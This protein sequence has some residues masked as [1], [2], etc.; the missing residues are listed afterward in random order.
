MIRRL[1]IV[2]ASAML[3]G[4]AVPP[5]AMG[6]SQSPLPE[7]LRAELK[8]LPLT[9]PDGTRPEFVPAALDP[10]RLVTVMVEVDGAPVAAV[11]AAAKDAGAELSDVERSALRAALRARQQPLVDAVE[12]LRGRVLA[13]TQDAFNG[14]KVTV[15][16]SALPQLATL[17]GVVAVHPVVNYERS[18]ETSVP[19]LGVPQQVWQDLELTG[20]GVTIGVIDTG[21]D[22]THADFGG[23]GTPEAYKANNPTVVEPGSFPT[24][25]VVGGHD[26]AGNRY[27]GGAPPGDPAAIP[28]PDPDPLD[29]QGHGTHVAG[30]AAG[31]GVLADG[32]AYSGPY[33][34]TTPERDF[35]VGPGVAPEASLYALKVFGCDGS[36]NL[37]VD[38]VNWA[39]ENDLD[40]LNLSLGSPFSSAG[41][42][43]IEAINNAVRAGIVVVVSAGNNGNIP[44]VV[45]S[46]SVAERAISVAAVD[47]N[48]TFPMADVAVGG[49]TITLRNLNLADLST[50]VTGPV[51]VLADNPATPQNE[52]LGCVASDYAGIPEGSVVVT[53]RGQCALLDR[54][55]LGQRAGAAAVVIVSNVPQAPPFL[56]AIEGVTIPVLGATPEQGAQVSAG[57]GQTATIT[58][59]GREA[60]PDFR[61]PAPFTSA[62]P[63]IVGD[64]AKPDLAAPGVSIISAGVGTGAGPRTLSGTS[65]S[66]PHVA[67]VAALVRQARPDDSVESVKAALVNTADPQAARNYTTL[68]LGSGVVDPDEAITTPVVAVGDAGTASL[69][70]GFEESVR[71]VTERK[72]VQLRNTGSTAV[73]FAVSVEQSSTPDGE[74][75]VSVRPRA[76]TVAAGETANVDVTVSVAPSTDLPPGGVQAASGTVV[77]TPAT[78]SAAPV[79]RVPYV[80]VHRAVSDLQ[81]R[82]ERVRPPAD[83]TVEFTTTNRSP[84]A[85]TIDVYAWG[86][87]DGS[88]D[89]LIRDGKAPDIRAVGVQAFPRMMPL[90]RDRQ[91]RGLGVFAINTHGRHANASAIEHDVLLDV[92]ENGQ[93]DF[94]VVGVDLGLVTGQGLTGQASSVTFDVRTGQAVRAFPAIGAANSSTLLLPF[95]LSDVAVDERNPDFQYDA[96]ASSLIARGIDEVDGRASFNAFDQPVE[97][98]GFAEVPGRTAIDWT[99]DVDAAQLRETPVEGW[100]LVY[101]ENRTGPQQADL[102]RLGGRPG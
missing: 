59:G 1:A 102:V 11:R 40:V 20:E 91:A 93:I 77:F 25:K 19:F 57:R 67:G 10:D 4:A 78:G 89:D 46:P 55:V 42:V 18:N 97:T 94:A 72:T 34:A 79:L 98:G 60:N 6:A 32:T 8:E 62:G 41:D 14:V 82:P 9:G 22:Y 76:V 101:T 50:P 83:G 17:P 38:A 16:T 52:A 37:L 69:S 70:F 65:M 23:A 63:S 26:F 56:G 13:T 61:T 85:G 2:S 3:L 74:T 21:I 49:R 95:V 87:S 30:T 80:L 53:L 35:A 75:S 5:A 39:V 48:E 100:M 29:C 68:R 86:L 73:R 44:Y 81:T 51:A 28:V 43:E 15:P 31:G 92:D 45:G 71:T 88:G 58:D 64:A 24:A 96:A 66:A 99:A 33:D 27:D 12:S 47:S 90:P 84:V 54:G 7:R 36:T